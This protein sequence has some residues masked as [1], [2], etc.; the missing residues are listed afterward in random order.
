MPKILQKSLKIL[1]DPLQIL[2]FHQIITKILKKHQNPQISSQN[3]NIAKNPSEI[4]S[5]STNFL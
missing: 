5:K 2:K 4:F 1:K 3:P